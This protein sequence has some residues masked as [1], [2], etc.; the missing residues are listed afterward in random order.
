MHSLVMFLWLS[1]VVGFFASLV[2]L[3]QFFRYS[4]AFPSENFSLVLVAGILG[5]LMF[6]FS[7]LGALAVR[8]GSRVRLQVCLGV[9]TVCAF[10]IGFLPRVPLGTALRPDLFAYIGGLG[11]LG[12]VMLALSDFREVGSG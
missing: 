12:M 3:V 7:L 8:R 6:V 5:V 4:S 11:T 10:A 2:D 9:S 1:L